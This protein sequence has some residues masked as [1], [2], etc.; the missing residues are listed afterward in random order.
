MKN[1]VFEG[2]ATALITP[3]TETG[4]DY[5][6]F[7]RLVEWQVASG[8]VALVVAGTTGEAPTLTDREWEELCR[9]ALGT[10]DG[11]AKIIIGCGSNSTSSAVKRVKLARSLGA[12]AALA[13]TPYY[14]K[15]SKEGLV[16]HYRALCGAADIPV[17]AYNVPSRTGVD[18]GVETLESL[19]GIENF[20]GIKEATG[21]V[22]RSACL[23]SKFG[24]ELPVYSGSDEVN[25]PILSI[26]GSGMISV[27][28]NVFPAEC[29]GL[30]NAASS[31]DIPTARAYSAGFYPLVAAL[32][33]EVNPI[34]V[35]T[36]MARLGYCDEIFRL[37][38]C[39]MEN[40]KREKLFREYEA[41]KSG[42]QKI[43][44]K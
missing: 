43:L 1:K 40:G 35:K 37:P 7:E 32:F 15:A 2:V 3:F 5:G 10:S 31:G 6:A 25:F 36:V 26:G 16:G 4:V 38:L 33:S 28:S 23:L 22:A 20:A 12:D 42:S 17:I 44:H 30:W 13:V 18:L 41:A 9:V 27:L 14:N 8:A 11:R 24:D 39:A 19:V 29:V 34:P 21:S